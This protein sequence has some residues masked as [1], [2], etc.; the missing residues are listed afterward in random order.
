[1]A[2]D[3]KVDTRK[4]AEFWNWFSKNC[5]NF[6]TEFNNTE[7]LSELDRWITRLGNFSWEVGPGKIKEYALVISPGG[8]LKLLKKS[9]RIV[10]EAKGCDAWEFYYAKQPKKWKLVFDFETRDHVVIEIDGSQW[11]YVLLRYEDGMFEIII[12]AP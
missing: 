10:G 6:G 1:M 4:I 11:E 8:D 3:G 12:K 7:L 5:D 2:M 9:K